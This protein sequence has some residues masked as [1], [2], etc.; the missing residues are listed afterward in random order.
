[1]TNVPESLGLSERDWNALDNQQKQK[2]VMGQAKLVANHQLMAQQALEDDDR[3]IRQRVKQAQATIM[4]QC[5]CGG[6]DLVD[7]D[8]DVR[9]TVLGDVNGTEALHMLSAQASTTQQVGTG[10][11]N[12]QAAP[13]MQQRVEPMTRPT[14]QPDSNSNN[15]QRWV[16]PFLAG[17]LV[18][19]PLGFWGGTYWSGTASQ[20][21]TLNAPDANLSLTNRPPA[22]G[23]DGAAKLK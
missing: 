14:T 9:I 8:D 12:T 20:S 5:G 21:T 19:S 15:W 13:E 6:T 3:D 16:L 22:F 10:N 2:L 11:R 23:L 18:G 4:D 1:M 7:G 17:T